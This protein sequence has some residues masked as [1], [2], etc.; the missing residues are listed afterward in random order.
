MIVCRSGAR[1]AKACALLAGHGIVAADLTSGTTAWAA[2]GQELHRP[3][4]AARAGWA[5]ERQ[6][7]D[8]G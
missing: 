6:V 5:M 7:P 3:S 4:G 2:D 1:S 8:V